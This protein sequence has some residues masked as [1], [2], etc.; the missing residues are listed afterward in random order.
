MCV[1]LITLSVV[2][3]KNFAY[4]NID[5]CSASL[6]GLRGPPKDT[7]ANM[8]WLVPCI[9]N[10]LFTGRT[11][12]LAKIINAISDS[13]HILQQ[14]RFIITGM[15]GQGKSEVC[16]QIA[17]KVRQEY[18]KLPFLL[19]LD[20]DIAN[21]GSFWGIF[22][23]E[24]SSLSIAKSN[25]ASVA[26]SLGSFLDTIDD[27]LQL[28]SNLKTSWLLILDNAND[29]DFDYQGYFPSGETGTII[30]T[31]RVA[32]CSRYGNIGSEILSNLDSNECVE[33]FSKA[34][35]LP[36]TE[37]SSHTKA[38]ENV[39][40]NL[41]S[42]TLAI[43]QA[44]A[45]I[46]RGHCSIEEFPNKFRHQRARLLQFSPKQAKS[47]YSHVFATFEASACVLEESPSLEAKNALCL[48][49]ILAIIHFSEFSLKIFE[50]A[51]R[52]S[53]ELRKVP[54][55]KD[56]SINT[57]FDWHVSQLPGFVL[58]ELIE[59]DEYRLQEASNV[60]ASL[61]LITK[62]KHS[63]F[64]EISM[65]SLVHAWAGDRFNSEEK[66]TQA[67]RAAG[68]ILSLALSLEKPEIWLMYG[69]QLR[70]HTHSYI[71]LNIPKNDSSHYSEMIV[72]MLVVGQESGI[73]YGM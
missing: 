35:E 13:R 9:V 53:Q 70:P 20:R 3:Y 52:K 66:K 34:A 51:W 49:E 61:F 14:H 18:V 2:F 65:H 26:R 37:W 5:I 19:V 15:G 22:W 17:N 23:V 12:T 16:L 7:S 38:A 45:Y 31:S 64:F 46:A 32:D 59:W 10:N 72:P 48:L 62:R 6:P 67:W 11:E 36:V 57:L 47:R 58:A 63:N 40:S 21:F 41:S 50:F 33:L 56:Q 55:D 29:P 54:Y 4:V 60:L 44:G 68:S 25:F 8:V 69:R 43:I 30:M 28:I 71:S 73:C 1:A 42:H 27:V 39:V 24:V